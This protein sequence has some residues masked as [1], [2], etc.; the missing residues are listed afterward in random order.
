MGFDDL[1]YL[2]DNQLSVEVQQDQVI[3]MRVALGVYIIADRSPRVI[4]LGGILLGFSL[5]G[6]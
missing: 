6:I 2:T 1:D 4:P 3:R 5:Y